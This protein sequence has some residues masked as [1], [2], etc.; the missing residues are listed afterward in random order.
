MAGHQVISHRDVRVDSAGAGYT[1]HSMWT[2]FSAAQA[3]HAACGVFMVVLGAVAVGRAGFGDRLG[4]RTTEVLDITVSTVI[5]LVAIAVGLI[6]LF[7]ALSPAGR[8]TGGVM[9]VLLL[10]AGIVIAAGSDEFL[11][12]LHTESA[13]GWVL[14]VVG[15]IAVI[16]SVLPAHTVV[17]EADVVEYR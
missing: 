13:L 16:G 6:F 12:D 11:A 9:G 8:G 7:A 3:L 5:G 15:A 2:R 14:M 4:E 10:V 1:R 17:R